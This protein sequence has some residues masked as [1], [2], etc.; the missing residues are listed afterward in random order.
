MNN[1]SNKKYKITATVFLIIPF[2]VLLVLGIGENIAQ[3]S[4]SLIHVIEA[5]P[6][7][8]FGLI[9]W[10]KPYIGG[11]IFLILGIVLAVIYPFMFNEVSVAALVL[12]ELLLFLPPVIAGSLFLASSEAQ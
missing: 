1:A 6:L 8:I 5:A 10:K 2:L 12:A 4:G 11:I 3:I 9:A 7:V